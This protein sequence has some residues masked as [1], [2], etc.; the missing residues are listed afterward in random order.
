MR[1]LPLLL[2]AACGGAQW[3]PGEVFEAPLLEAWRP[4]VPVVPV[5]VDGQGPLLFLLDTATEG[6]VITR[7]AAELVGLRVAEP[8]RG[9]RS[10][11]VLRLGSARIE[12]ELDIV[13]GYLGRLH[14]VPVSRALGSLLW[15]E[16]AIEL[17]RARGVLRME[18]EAKVVGLAL[19]S[20]RL[21]IRVGG[22]ALRARVSTGSRTSVLGKGPVEVELAGARTTLPSMAGPDPVLGFA[23]LGGRSLRFD[24]ESLALT[25]PGAPAWMTRFGPEV[26]VTGHV[27]RVEAGRVWLRF[28][29]PP[30]L[31]TWLAFDLGREAP[32]KVLVYLAPRPAGPLSASIEGPDLGPETVRGAGEALTL[33]DVVP[34]PKDCPGD[35]CLAR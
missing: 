35:I 20:G 4:E 25:R 31:D 33:M 30:P 9:R 29:A 19:K 6:A 21:P 24:G 18:R 17:D 22:R 7:E 2:L 8:T 3:G 23:G 1:G 32:R 28:E 5:F 10:R 34:L 27:E 16:G 14:D 11:A 13:E 15:S 12:A 26:A